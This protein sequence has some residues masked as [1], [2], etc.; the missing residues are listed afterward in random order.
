MARLSRRARSA[1]SIGIVFAFSLVFGISAAAT[2][3]LADDLE[4]EGATFSRLSGSDRYGTMYKICAAGW[5]T[6]QTVYVASGAN[7]PDALAVSGLAGM[8]EAP[9]VLTAPDALSAKAKE[10]LVALAPTS[11]VILGGTSAVSESCEA[12]IKAAL[13]KASVTR[14]GGSDRYETAYKIYERGQDSGTWGSTAIVVT[15]ENFADAL[16]VSPLAYKGCMPVFLASQDGIGSQTLAALADGGFTDILIVGGTSAVSSG[17]EDALEAI[18]GTSHVKRIG[19]TDRYETS[20]LIAS[21]AVAKGILTYGTVGLA[22]GANFPDALAGGALLGKQGGVLL[23]MS[24]DATTCLDDPLGTH[25]GEVGSL[26]V[27]GGKAVISAELALRAKKA[28]SSEA[29]VYSATSYLAAAVRMANDDGIGYALN[30]SDR[31]RNPDV[32][33]TA[34]VYYALLDGGF[35]TDQLGTYAFHSGSICGILEKNGFT[36]YDFDAIKDALKPGDIL[37][38]SGHSEIVYDPATGSTIGAH[39][40]SDGCKGDGDGTEVGVNV[41]ALGT[42]GWDSYTYVYRLE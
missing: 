9:I 28:V 35:T 10:T 42:G 11:V 4:L 18:V 31:F 2:P 7:F 23:L 22:T 41:G 30:T 40:D 16:S 12:A 36:R 6:S 14:V 25:A 37:W 5:E 24:T 1:L 15:G 32:D 29:Q 33:C 26:Y 21:Y 8:S 13:P 19:G 3:A 20:R 38:R 34:F 39:E 27:F 17:T